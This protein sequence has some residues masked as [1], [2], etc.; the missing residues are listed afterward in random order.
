MFTPRKITGEQPGIQRSFI[1]AA[2]MMFVLA[3]KT[4]RI[5]KVNV[6]KGTQGGFELF[7]KKI[8]QGWGNTDAQHV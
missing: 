2:F 5:S 3:G 1:F 7:V 4:P 8:G 6:R